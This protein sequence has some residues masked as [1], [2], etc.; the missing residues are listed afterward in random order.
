MFSLNTVDNPMLSI[1]LSTGN[2][3]GHLLDTHGWYL[4]QML[5]LRPFQSYGVEQWGGGGQYKI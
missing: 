3:L 4:K 5:P 1:L 2:Y